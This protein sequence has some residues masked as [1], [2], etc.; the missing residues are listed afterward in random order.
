ML[1]SHAE[2]AINAIN[3]PTWQLLE[4]NQNLLLGGTPNQQLMRSDVAPYIKEEKLNQ[5]KYTLIS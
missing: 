5:K 1:G 2:L 3:V 4:S